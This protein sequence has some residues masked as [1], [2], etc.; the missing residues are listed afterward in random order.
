V[1]WRVLS[2]LL[3]AMALVTAACGDDDA[4]TTTAAGPSCEVAD[5]NLVTPGQLTVATAAM[6]ASS[7]KWGRRSFVEDTPW[8]LIS[9]LIK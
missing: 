4:A 8:S 2:A 5:L 6:A 1:K 9:V 3:L 7:R